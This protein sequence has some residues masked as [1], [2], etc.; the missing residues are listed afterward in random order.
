M[1]GTQNVCLFPFGLGKRAAT[2]NYGPGR[3]KYPSVPESLRR[4]FICY[5]RSI[6][7]AGDSPLTSTQE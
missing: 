2:G 3:L 6:E 1:I 5:L 7:I 4:D